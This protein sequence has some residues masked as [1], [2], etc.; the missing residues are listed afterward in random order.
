MNCD[1]IDCTVSDVFENNIYDLNPH[2]KYIPIYKDIFERDKSKNREKASTEMWSV[3]ILECVD[4]ELNKYIKYNI[5]DR[6]QIVKDKKVNVEDELFIK[7]RERYSIDLMSK[8]E[9]TLK[10]MYAQLDDRADFLKKNPYTVEWFAVDS[11]G[12][13]MKAGNT[14][15]P[16]F[17]K[18]N[19]RDKMILDTEDIYLSLKRSQDLF[20]KDKNNRRVVGGRTES[21]SEQ[22]KL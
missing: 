21:L 1:F 9:K 19:E 4:E 8:A 20:V 16:R 22:G 2:L 6:M 17:L 18:P 12:L 10:D 13:P 7:A 15:V 5:E 11:K 14:L 3:F